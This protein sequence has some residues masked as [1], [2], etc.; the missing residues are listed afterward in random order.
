MNGLT[1]STAA[2]EGYFVQFAKAMQGRVT[3]P[4]MVTGGFRSAE[5]MSRAMEGDAVSIVGLAR[6][7]CTDFDGPGRLLKEGG[8][9]DRPEGRLRLGPGWLGPQSPFKLIK[10]ANGFAVMSWY[11]QQLRSVAATGELDNSLGVLTAFRRE[12]QAQKAW[13]GEA[14]TAGTFA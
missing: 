1:A 5:A 13:L 11:Y 12:R 4:M 8:T 7:M 9:L 2:R 14:K 3:V 6:P 10:S